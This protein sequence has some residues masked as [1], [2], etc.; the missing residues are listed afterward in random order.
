MRF[1]WHGYEG[2][3]WFEVYAIDQNKGL[4]EARIFIGHPEDFFYQFSYFMKRYGLM[5]VTDEVKDDTPSPLP[6][7]ST[8]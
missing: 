1:V 5:D 6:P 8:L 2:S 3:D 4:P 7:A